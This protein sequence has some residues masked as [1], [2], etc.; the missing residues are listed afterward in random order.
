V[1]K[2]ETACAL[3]DTLY[4]GERNMIVINLSEFQEAHSVSS[5]KGA[6]PG[7]VGYGKGGV[8]T[9]AV[10]RRPYSVVLL[11]EMEKAHPDVLELFFQVFD[12]GSMEDG[13]GVTIDF[14]NTLILLTSNA[15]QDVITQ[16]C[17]GGQRPDPQAL[18]QRLRPH[19]LRQFSPA[20]LG[21]LVL[22][23]YYPLGDAQIRRIVSLKLARLA[24]RFANHHRSTF[25]WDDRVVASITARCTEVDSGARNID[26]ILTQT[27]LP[28]LSER[29][30]ER[31]CEQRPFNAVVLGVA[32]DGQFAYTFQDAPLDAAGARA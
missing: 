12:K 14:R 27:V 5:L 31:I 22:V 4:G 20:F 3:A 30:L 2:T 6:P 26:Y 8:L 11:D 32:A 18:V 23:P 15:A 24:Q 21:R 1:G 29:V 25:T 10:R 28:Q 19:L 7:Y 16:A 13:E 9:E 17:E